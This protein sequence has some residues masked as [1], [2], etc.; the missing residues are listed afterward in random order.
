MLFLA[1]LAAQ[2]VAPQPS[3]LRTF[4]DWTVGCDNG[5]RCEAIA[6]LP[7][8]EDWEG[9]TTLGIS[10]EAGVQAGPTFML[11][12]LESAPAQLAADGIPLA[13][14]FSAGADG[15]SVMDEGGDLLRALRAAR[16]IEARDFG[17]ATVASISLAGASAAM[18]YM[19]EV[20]GRVGTTAALV[21]PGARPAVSR[22]PALPQ[23][24]RTPPPTDAAIAPDP[25]R[26]ATIERETGCAD[27]M[28]GSA[29]PDADAPVQIATGTALIL[30]PCGS[31]AYN[32][33]SLPVLARGGR[34]AVAPFDFQP[35]GAPPLLTNAFWD[36]KRRVLMEY[37]KGRGLG[38]CGIASEYVWDGARF[39]LIRYERMDE[40]RGS[41]RRI[42]TWRA[43]LGD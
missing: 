19:D 25:A 38:D 16:V 31:G 12:D 21:R 34:V 24:R 41:L 26:L 20:Q 17:G 2:A 15:I 7:E 13:V 40:C 23:V 42:T 10:R 18:L 32:F 22:P 11:P 36:E 28:A 29:R 5:R 8:G 37:N 9:W 30:L 1:L 14:S 35:S 33:A 43:E 3:E 6:L 27:E 4:R 39:R